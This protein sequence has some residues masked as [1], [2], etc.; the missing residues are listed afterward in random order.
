MLALFMLLGVTASA[1]CDYAQ[2]GTEPVEWLAFEILLDSPVYAEGELICVTTIYTNTG[3][4]PIRYQPTDYNT[5]SKCVVTR[6]DGESFT[7]AYPPITPALGPSTSRLEPGDSALYAYTFNCWSPLTPGDYSAQAF[8]WQPTSWPA[9]EFQ[10]DERVVLDGDYVS[11]EVPFTVLPAGAQAPA[12]TRLAL[13]G[14]P[15]DAAPQPQ[16][17]RNSLVAS[18]Q[19]LE[20]A[21][22]KATQDKA[23]QEVNLSRGEA[24]VTLPV[25]RWPKEMQDEHLPA[26]PSMGGGLLVPVRYVAESLGM[27]VHWDAKTKTANIL[28]G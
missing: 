9:D 13:N 26:I 4:E 20:Q 8:A 17:V 14:N 2:E 19:A 25:G 5:K 6:A 21:G 23:K 24:S 22:V 28:T 7:L 16:R 27:R 18:T 11:N 3:P 15:L 10:P 12:S 1:I